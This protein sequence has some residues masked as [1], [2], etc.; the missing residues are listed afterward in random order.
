[1]V[2]IISDIGNYR[3]L[4]EDAVGYFENLS[5]RFYAIADGMGGHN[6]GEIASNLAIEG[7]IQYFKREDLTDNLK[8]EL[9]E[10]IEK[11]N[12]NI[13]KTSRKKD[14]YKGMGTTVTACIICK[15]KMCIGH[16][17]DSSCIIIDKG[18]NIKKVTKDHSLVQ[19]LVD[20]GSITKEE[21][22]NHPNKNIITRALG[23]NERVEVDIYEFQ[24]DKI[25]RV[26]LC[27]DG[28]TNGV[29]LQEMLDCVISYSEEVACEKLVDMSK[30]NGSKD[31]ISVIVFKGADENDR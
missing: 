30:K 20:S 13:Y 22:C 5:I 17:G 19:E 31:N 29:S 8:N 1:M 26:L 25:D 10:G 7:L 9:L 18:K 14:N 12:K 23:I 6:A 11:V 3:E 16:V 4:N 28:L 27:T 21:A 24:V 15:D 2:G